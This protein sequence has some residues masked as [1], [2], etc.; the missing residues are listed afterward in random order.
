MAKLS[1]SMPAL[2]VPMT[3]MPLKSPFRSLTQCVQEVIKDFPGD[4]Q[5]AT[6]G[7]E[8]GHIPMSHLTRGLSY[9]RTP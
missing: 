9:T 2:I 8:I 7:V 5:A 4:S 6:S 1:V 3:N